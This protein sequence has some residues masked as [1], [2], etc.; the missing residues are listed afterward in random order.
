MLFYG[1]WWG[2]VVIGDIQVGGGFCGVFYRIMGVYGG[3]CLWVCSC[4]C[5]LGDDADSIRWFVVDGSL[6]YQC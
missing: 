1:F 5:V 3:V 4:G 6:S 2:V